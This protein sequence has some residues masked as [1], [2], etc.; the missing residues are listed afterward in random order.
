MPECNEKHPPYSLKKLSDKIG[1]LSWKSA[2]CHQLYSAIC[3]CAGSVWETYRLYTN[4]DWYCKRE[5]KVSVHFC[6]C[7][8][9]TLCCSD[10]SCVWLFLPVVYSI[11]LIKY[12]FKQISKPV[13]EPSTDTSLPENVFSDFDFSTHDL[14]NAITLWPNSMNYLFKL[15]FCSS[16]AI[17]F[18][19]FLHGHCRLALTFDPV[20]FS[21]SCGPATD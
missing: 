4:G 7:Y 17:E 10:L 21:M 14:E 16:G 20:T 1:R 8:V 12:N 5:T 2:V 18:T 15:P 19:R 9:I 13:L 6:Y 11:D 3:L